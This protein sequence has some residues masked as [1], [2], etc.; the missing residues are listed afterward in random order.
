[1]LITCIVMQWRCYASFERWA[2]GWGG[3]TGICLLSSLFLFRT[4]YVRY[5]MAFWCMFF[6][7]VLMMD[8]GIFRLASLLMECSCMPPLTPAVIVMRGLVCH[9]RICMVLIS[10]SNLVCL[11]VR[12][13]SGIMSWQYV[14]SMN[15]TGSLEEGVIG[16][17]I[18]FGAPIMYRMSSLNLSWHWHVVCVHVQLRSHFG[19]VCWGGVLFRWHALVNVKNRVFLVSLQCLCD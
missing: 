17:C 15:S 7:R 16:I 18:W 3:G 2:L 4:R 12:A 13:W 9:P 8:F 1:M 19:I 11:C 10:E 5:L 14:N 6:M